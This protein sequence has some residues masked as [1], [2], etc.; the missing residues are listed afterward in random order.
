MFPFIISEQ[1][2]VNFISLR[3]M[4]LV[5]E[6]AVVNKN[7]YTGWPNK[8]SATYELSWNVLKTHQQG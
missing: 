5:S 6:S 7:E 1:I 3:P 4:V 2:I 8:K